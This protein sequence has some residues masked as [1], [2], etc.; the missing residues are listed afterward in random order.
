MLGYFVL[1]WTPSYYEW[2]WEE[3]LHFEAYAQKI[4]DHALPYVE[5]VIPHLA[6]RVGLT[7]EWLAQ[8]MVCGGAER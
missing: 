5:G 7:P 3:P 2:E 8:V 4:L 6:R 1:E